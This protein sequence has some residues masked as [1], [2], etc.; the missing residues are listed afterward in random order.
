MMCLGSA[1]SAA[2]FAVMWQIPHSS[3]FAAAEPDCARTGR[4]ARGGL[5]VVAL[6]L[7]L[8]AL[9]VLAM[10]ADCVSGT[11]CS[12]PTLAVSATA[13]DIVETF[14]DVLTLGIDSKT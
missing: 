1:T 2:L 11:V 10:G 4:G 12:I 9:L 13:G 8:L 14:G 6:A 5:A 3:G 7:L